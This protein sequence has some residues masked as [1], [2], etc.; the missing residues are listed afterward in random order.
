[1]D[2]KTAF[3]VLISEKGI[4]ITELA[5][6]AGV[7]QSYLSQRLSAGEFSPKFAPKVAE[8]LGMDLETFNKVLEE[9][10]RTYDTTNNKDIEK[11]EVIKEEDN[12]IP[13]IRGVSPFFDNVR[14]LLPTVITTNRVFN[15]E[16]YKETHDIDYE[17]IKTVKIYAYLT[18]ANENYFFNCELLE[19]L[20]AIRAT[21]A[22]EIK[23]TKAFV[24]MELTKET[25]FGWNA[26]YVANTYQQACE[27]AGLIETYILK[28]KTESDT[29][30]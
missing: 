13:S 11:K 1:M 28:S 10:Q 19:F 30:K 8:A 16:W 2:F 20:T 21:K 9:K 5:A 17:A 14:Q 27:L 4:T 29:D 26:T 18:I 15:V 3:K 23:Q 6:K 7:S 12:E 25:I 22:R 24:Y